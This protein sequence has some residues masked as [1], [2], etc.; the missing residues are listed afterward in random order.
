[1]PFWRAVGGA[2]QG[3]GVVITDIGPALMTSWPG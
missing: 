2:N 3:D 1:M